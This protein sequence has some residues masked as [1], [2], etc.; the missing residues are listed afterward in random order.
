LNGLTR[1]ETPSLAAP[2]SLPVHKLLCNADGG[3]AGCNGN[4]K[5]RG[6]T[7]TSGKR[8]IWT[9][10]VRLDARALGIPAGW[11]SRVGFL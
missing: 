2:S 9:G 11:K 5:Y 4:E 7:R 10:K 3:S 6:L 8:A 1:L